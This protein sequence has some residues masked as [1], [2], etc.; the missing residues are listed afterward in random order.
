MMDEEMGT[1]NPETAVD[2]QYSMSQATVSSKR[3]DRKI[4]SAFLKVN[5]LRSNNIYL[6]TFV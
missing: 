6:M 4:S 1:S 2:H 5:E 3:K